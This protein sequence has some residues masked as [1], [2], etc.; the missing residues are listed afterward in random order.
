[1][2]Y[3]RYWNSISFA[4]N[5]RTMKSIVNR[6]FIG[7]CIFL[8]SCGT[9][10]AQNTE[11]LD[12]KLKVALEE[13]YRKDKAYAETKRPSFNRTSWIGSKISDLIAKWGPPTRIVSDG[14]DGQIV[15]YE[16]ST[17]NSGGVYTP[18]SITTATNGVGQTVITDYKEAQDTRWASQYSEST[19]IYVDKNKIITKVD[20]KNDRKTYGNTF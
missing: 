11:K 18:G 8:I 1:M 14:A 13:R 19:A 10:Y 3:S 16:S 20:F 9:A 7:G 5:T 2:V 12:K 6:F 15:I 17:Y 4:P